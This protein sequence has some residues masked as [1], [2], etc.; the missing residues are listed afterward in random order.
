MKL[1]KDEKNQRLVVRV[2]QEE[3]EYIE[4]K[5]SEFQFKNTSKFIREALE[6]YITSKEN[7]RQY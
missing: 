5:A 3:K 6:F 2:T 4:K 1:N 7:T